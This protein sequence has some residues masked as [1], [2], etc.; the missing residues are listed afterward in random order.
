M[1]NVA[2]YNEAQGGTER[3]I[4]KGRKTKWREKEPNEEGDRLIK[5]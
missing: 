2:F 5:R 4:E 1:Q 3:G